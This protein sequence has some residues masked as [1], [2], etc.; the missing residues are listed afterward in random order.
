M[1]LMKRT[2]LIPMASLFF[3]TGCSSGGS[4][5]SQK[6]SITIP[7]LSNTHEIAALNNSQKNSVGVAGGIAGN[8]YR[9]G[10]I[11]L[12]EYNDI[13]RVYI[14][15]TDSAD[16][17]HVVLKESADYAR[18]K[19]SAENYSAFSSGLKA[20]ENSNI[21]LNNK[22]CRT[23]IPN[24]LVYARDYHNNNSQTDIPNALGYM[25]D[26]VTVTDVINGLNI[27][28]QI[29]QNHS[30]QM[31]EASSNNMY[32]PPINTNKKAKNRTITSYQEGDTTYFSNGTSSRR[33]GDTI[34]HS[35]GSNSTKSGN[36]IYHS[37][38]SNSTKSGNYIYNSDG[39]KCLI[40]NNTVTCK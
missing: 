15:I 29:V 23:D 3:F 10:F 14:D 13:L 12:D 36:Y 37:D 4:M 27:L 21:K 19:E 7:S 32:Y 38:G 35:D 25:K 1:T 9:E 33:S 34:Y 6:T 26:K 8:C 16:V 31:L 17:S 24:I 40:S 2:L 30:E 39:S 11:N 5:S 22:I 28:S 20:A 18:L